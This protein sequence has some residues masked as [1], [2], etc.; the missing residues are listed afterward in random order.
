[1]FGDDLLNRAWQQLRMGRARGVTDRQLQVFL[2]DAIDIVSPLSRHWRAVA[3]D[4]LQDREGDVDQFDRGRLVL[5][6]C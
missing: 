2:A 6:P 4:P 5:A 1:M 3:S